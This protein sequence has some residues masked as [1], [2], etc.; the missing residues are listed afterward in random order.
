MMYC[1]HEK[2]PIS[3]L[4]PLFMLLLQ[5][6][7]YFL[8]AKVKDDATNKKNISTY[9]YEEVFLYSQIF[10]LMRD[11]EGLIAAS[12]QFQTCSKVSE[13]LVSTRF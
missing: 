5:K 7:C 8:F 2:K 1:F 9:I 11:H 6:L 4:G 12:L 10:T 13:N 3:D